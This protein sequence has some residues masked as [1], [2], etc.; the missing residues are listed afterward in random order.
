MKEAVRASSPRPHLPPTRMETMAVR[1]PPSW[2]QAPPRRAREVKV[3]ARRALCPL[4]AK[5]NL[6]LCLG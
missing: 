3:R 2:T 5:F 6:N 4:P 1:R